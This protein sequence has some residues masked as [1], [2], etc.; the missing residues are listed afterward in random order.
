MNDNLK[1]LFGSDSDESD[2]EQ[3]PGTAPLAF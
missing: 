1:E 2:N 3:A